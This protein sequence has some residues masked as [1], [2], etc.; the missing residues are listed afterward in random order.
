[1]DNLKLINMG[2]GNGYRP[3]VWIKSFERERAM[4]Y[5]FNLIDEDNRN[6]SSSD[7]EDCFAETESKKVL[8]LSPERFLGEFNLNSLKN[9]K[10]VLSIITKILKRS[11]LLRTNNRFVMH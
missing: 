1:M 6:L 5:V 7:L 4:S 3:V 8:V 10:N 2:K 11:I 9:K